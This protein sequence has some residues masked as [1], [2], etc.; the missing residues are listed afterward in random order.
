MKITSLRTLLLLSFIVP[1]LSPVA[2]AQSLKKTAVTI[3]GNG[4]GVFDIDETVQYTLT[5]SNTGTTD[6]ADVV[7]TDDSSACIQLDTASLVIDPPDG[8]TNNSSGSALNVAL[9]TPLPPG[10]TIAITF[11]AIATADGRCCN[12]ATWTSSS[13]GGLSDRLPGDLI[14]D[15]P[16]CHYVAPMTAADYDAVL[17]KQLLSSG[18]LAP[19]SVVEF[20]VYIRNSGRRPLRNAVFEDVLV[21]GFSN[22]VVDAGLSYDPATGRIYVDPRTYGVGEETEYF[23]R[24]TLPCTGEGTLTNTARFTFEDN[25]GTVYTRTDSETATWDQPDFAASTMRWTDDSMDG[26][27]VVTEGENVHFEILV[28]NRGGCDATDVVVTDQ[29]DPRFLSTNPPLVIDAGGTYDPA[30]GRI[31]WNASTTPELAG[32][33]SGNT[34]TLGFTTQVDPATA[35]G[36]YIPNTVTIAPAGAGT[37]CPDLPGVIQTVVLQ[38]GPVAYGAV[39][40]TTI[41][42]RNDAVACLETAFQRMPA[43]LN[44]RPAPQ[45][46]SNP[47]AIDA[48][49]SQSDT[50]IDPVP[51]YTFAGDGAWVRPSCPDSGAL[52]GRVL[53]FYELQDDCTELLRV[54]KT[55]AGDVILTW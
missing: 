35:S 39:V 20:R 1:A 43:F 14:V 23:Y 29:L 15:E 13:G 36:E 31:E 51:P 30:T 7:I 25:D 3:D 42:L 18:C 37:A 26:D 48:A 8:S 27:S 52:N 33:T 41:L 32:L 9:R 54:R 28:N 24:A 55:V 53:I 10:E 47:P 19:G 2:H 44:V 5:F 11:N 17:D 22:P 46:C 21:S 34:V 6:L 40:P 12:Q 49:H 45:Q 50:I 4:N 38:N 16:T